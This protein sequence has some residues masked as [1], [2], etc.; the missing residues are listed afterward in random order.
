[1]NRAN[2]ALIGPLTLLAAIATTSIT[3][4]EDAFARKGRHSGDDLSQAASVRNS[5]LT[6]FAAA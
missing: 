1:M 6:Q 3:V 4:T 2:L 5:Y